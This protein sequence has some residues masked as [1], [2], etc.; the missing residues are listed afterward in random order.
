MCRKKWSFFVWFSC[1]FFPPA[2]V[3]SWASPAINFCNPCDDR[4]GKGEPFWR[5]MKR[6][7]NISEWNRFSSLRTTRR[8][9]DFVNERLKFVSND[10]REFLLSF[11]AFK[12]L[13]GLANKR[14]GSKPRL[15]SWWF[16]Q[17]FAGAVYEI[18]QH[19]V[20]EFIIFSDCFSTTCL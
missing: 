16:C 8:H 13:C 19:S 4:W 3:H 5:A 6:M 2:L 11:K 17:I 7:G 15:T 20:S 10:H 12:Q 9:F 18:E 1:V 14:R